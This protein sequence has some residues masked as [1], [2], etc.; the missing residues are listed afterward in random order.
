MVL[1]MGYNSPDDVHRRAHSTL[2]ITAVLIDLAKIVDWS[3]CKVY[4]S[5]VYYSR[6]RQPLT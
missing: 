4:I 5:I 3:F 6:V 1:I 2:R